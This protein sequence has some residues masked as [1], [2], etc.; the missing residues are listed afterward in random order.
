M[1]RD[2][3]LTGT[4]GNFVDTRCQLTATVFNRNGALSPF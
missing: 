1:L 4:T 2:N 3:V